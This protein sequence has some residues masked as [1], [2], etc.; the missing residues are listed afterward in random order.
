MVLAVGLRDWYTRNGARRAAL[1]DLADTSGPRWED[2]ADGTPLTVDEILGLRHYAMSVL[3][4]DRI[5]D[6]APRMTGLPEGSGEIFSGL[7]RWVE[8]PVPSGL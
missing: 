1:H 6:A 2:L 8:T 7:R 4:D 3:Y 5:R